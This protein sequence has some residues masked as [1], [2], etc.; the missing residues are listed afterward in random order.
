MDLREVKVSSVDS[1]R[2]PWELARKE[3][4]SSLI[5]KKLPYIND[6]EAIILDIGCGD[7]WLI[8]QLA[9]DFTKA[10]FIAV[11]IAFTDELLSAYRQRLDKNSF[12]LHKT[13]EDALNGRDLKVDL[14]LLLDVIEHIEDDVKFLKHVKTFTANITDDTNFLITVP[15][16]QSLFCK[17]DVFLGHYRRYNN[18]LLKENT[19]KAGLKPIHTGYFFSSLLPL[20]LKD[21]ILEKTGLSK[22]EAKGI[23]DWK[24]KPSDKVIK[25]VLLADYKFT[26]LLKSVGINFPGLSNYIICR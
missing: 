18:R 5:K 15:A 2:H 10:K 9:K 19:K 6:K 16:Y 26:K 25:S 7:T 1:G 23:G 13:L 4:V 21:V 20:R 8:E 11:D 17:H 12:E 22:A 24:E 14:I 3:V